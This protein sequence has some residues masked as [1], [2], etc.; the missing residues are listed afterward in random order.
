MLCARLREEAIDRTLFYLRFVFFPAF[1]CMDD[2][3]DRC[4]EVRKQLLQ[5]GSN[6]EECDFIDCIIQC[7]PVEYDAV[8]VPGKYSNFSAF[9]QGLLEAEA[10]L[11]HT[12]QVNMINTKGPVRR[13]SSKAEKA[14]NDK[15]AAMETELGKLTREFEV[16]KT[17]SAATVSQLESMKKLMRLLEANDAT[18]ATG[19]A[20][21]SEE[22]CYKIQA[23]TNAEHVGALKA[24]LEDEL[25]LRSKQLAEKKLNVDEMRVE[26][27]RMT[28]DRDMVLSDQESFK[29]QIRS[30]ENKLEQ[31]QKQV[32]GTEEQ[33]DNMNAYRSDLEAHIQ[34]IEKELHLAQLERNELAL[35]LTVIKEDYAAL[36]VEREDLGSQLKAARDELQ[37]TNDQLSLAE[38][39]AHDMRETFEFAA[40]RC[41]I[42]ATHLD[43][44]EA[45][46]C[47]M[48]ANHEAETAEWNSIH[49]KM[50]E[51]YLKTRQALEIAE[52]ALAGIKTESDI[53]VKKADWESMIARLE[54]LEKDS[55]EHC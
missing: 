5:S 3:L 48:R 37:E 14:S 49:D 22:K 41:D 53:V 25:A 11:R 28:F 40:E 8:R 13:S 35:E 52:A 55:W 6:I 2:Y 50:N 4:C 54:A 34:A 43:D 51:D 46:Q 27:A 10:E 45:E 18:L 12:K 29:S 24:P 23:L 20:K 21:M 36:E 44:S 19:M 1:S 39:A 7:L 33:R 31:M 32:S 17:N 30:L 16:F 26:L 15:I 38:T 9:S 42:L 47:A